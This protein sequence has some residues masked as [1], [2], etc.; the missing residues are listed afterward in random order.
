MR[1][2]LL[3]LLAVAGIA[4]SAYGLRRLEAQ[5]RRQAADAGPAR[6][7]FLHRPEGLASVTE[8]ALAGFA[9][10]PWSHP[11]LCADIA[12]ALRATGWVRSVESVH[13]FPDR[14]IEVGCT[15]RRP[16]AMVHTPRGCCLIDADGVRLPGW[17]TN[18]PAFMLIV[19]VTEPP[20]ASGEAWSTPEVRSAIELIQ[21]LAAEAFSEQITGVVVQPRA[22][23]GTVRP[24]PLILATDRAGGRIVWGSPIGEEIEENTVEQKLRLLRGNFQ[25]F[26]RVDA[27]RP[28]IDVSVHPDRVI[29]GTDAASDDE[30]MAGL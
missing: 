15:Y 19:G 2:A 18:D 12:A 17:Y 9:D 8:S 21:L 20:P 10:V 26:G 14:R 25:R 22:T 4:G 1:S 16:V 30:A 3:A 28:L 24:G 5:V 7:V 6:I 13:R 29:T 27:D 11:T 23:S